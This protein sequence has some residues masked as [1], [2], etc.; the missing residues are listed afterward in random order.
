[1]SLNGLRILNTR[2]EHQAGAL[3]QMIR[4]AGGV[5]IALPTLVIEPLPP[6][7]LATL[8]ALSS[9]DSAIFVSANAADCFFQTFDTTWP[10]TIKTLAIGDA[11]ANALA[12][13][14]IQVHAV[15]QIADS[16]HLLALAPLQTIQQQS[17]L[18][19][20]GDQSRPLIAETL[21]ARGAHVHPIAVYRRHLPKKN[22]PFTHALWQDDAVDII[23]VLSQTALHN[24][25]ILFEDAAKDWIQSKPCIVISPR[26]VDIAQRYDIRDVI[27]SSYDDLLTT[28]TRLTHD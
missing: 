1:M 11:T 28:L 13:Q 7:W 5:P 3:S 9:I 25:F 10:T 24:L 12:Q 22:I 19:I 23:L 2:P 17:V 6:H 16:E 15:P 4:D 21:T 26:L 14:G 18:L 8:P 27:L 20:S